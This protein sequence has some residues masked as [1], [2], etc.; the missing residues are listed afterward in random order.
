MNPEDIKLMSTSLQFEYE[1]MSREIDGCDDIDLLRE[2]CK[3]VV[4]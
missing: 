2:M 1:K 3:F 4:K